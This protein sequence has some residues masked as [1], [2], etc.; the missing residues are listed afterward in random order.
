M[1]ALKGDLQVNC[2]KVSVVT[3]SLK[4]K[5]DKCVALAWVLITQATTSGV[6]CVRPEDWD[7]T[8]GG[9][10]L[11]GAVSLVKSIRLRDIKIKI[12]DTHSPSV[13]GVG[14]RT[15]RLLLRQ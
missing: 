10:K 5:Q 11:D 9:L 12:P 15:E 13:R 2:K 3:L 14:I 4:R 8:E 6:N 1:S 7:G